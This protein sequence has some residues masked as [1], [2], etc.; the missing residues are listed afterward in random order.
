MDEL[1]KFLDQF[2]TQEVKTEQEMLR[3]P[4]GTKIT[5]DKPLKYSIS[6]DY[7]PNN[8]EESRNRAE[9][10]I[11][12]ELKK[13]LKALKV[14]MLPVKYATLIGL[15]ILH[16]F[17]YGNIG[18]QQPVRLVWEGYFYLEFNPAILVK[19]NYS[20]QREQLN[21]LLA[22]KDNLNNSLILRPNR[23]LLDIVPYLN[24]KIGKTT[25][26][27][28]WV[29]SQA[30]SNQGTQYTYVV[31][32]YQRKKVIED[33]VKS[34]LGSM[35]D[36]F[37]VI[38]TSTLFNNITIKHDYGGHQLVLDGIQANTSLIKNLITIDELNISGYQRVT[39]ID[40]S[41]ARYTRD[42]KAIEIPLEDN[43]TNSKTNSKD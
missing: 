15:N 25:L 4:A 35:P 31:P 36:N 28:N 19:N 38:S 34:R 10:V 14:D 24:R 16:P 29:I 23:P 40:L 5:G 43:T 17:V 30:T 22:L 21:M 37:E 3:L 12:K 1:K 26:L 33:K 8:I 2:D 32:P 41:Q 9:Q 20:L 11:I 42:Y 6:Y 27:L 7:D 18:I 39:E 13:R